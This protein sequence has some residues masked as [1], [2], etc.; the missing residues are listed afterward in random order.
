MRVNKMYK[1]FL[2]KGILLYQLTPFY[3]CHFNYVT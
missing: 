1:G 2:L 3:F